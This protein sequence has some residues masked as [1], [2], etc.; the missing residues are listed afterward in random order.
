MAAI[1]E[2]SLIP[3]VG[4]EKALQKLETAKKEAGRH[5]TGEVR[6][7]AEAKKEELCH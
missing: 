5:G 2:A 7:T 6:K 1:S 4:H 3:M